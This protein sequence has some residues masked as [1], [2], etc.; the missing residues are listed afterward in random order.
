M[1]TTATTIHE[2]QVCLKLQQCRTQRSVTLVDIPVKLLIEFAPELSTSLTST[3]NASLQ[4]V[5]SPLESK[6][7]YV[8]SV[9]KTP[10]AASLDQ[11]RPVS[12]TPLPSLV[13]EN[14]ATYT[15]L[16]SSFNPHQFG[17]IK[18]TSITHYL[19]S[20]LDYIYS[21]LENRKTSVAAVLVDLS[22]TFDLVD[23]TAVI[24]KTLAVGLGK[25]FMLF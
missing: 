9:P 11:T 22:K 2:H 21:N 5:E 8:T 25:T 14:F 10:S 24:Q 18:T 16:K 20:C 15:V 1:P 19:V 7:S 6:I 17:N 4:Q 3:F 23:H 12:I 13:C